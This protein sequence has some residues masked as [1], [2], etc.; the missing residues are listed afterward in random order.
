MNAIEEA[1]GLSFTGGDQLHVTA[2]LGGAEIDRLIKERH[3][4]LITATA[5]YPQDMG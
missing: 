3:G 2:L 5:Q 4:R 1:T